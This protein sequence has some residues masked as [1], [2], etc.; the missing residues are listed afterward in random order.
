MGLDNRSPE[1]G[2]KRRAS[3]TERRVTDQK[4]C[5]HEDPAKGV[6]STRHIGEKIQTFSDS[7]QNANKIQVAT[8]QRTLV[9][10]IIGQDPSARRRSHT[11]STDE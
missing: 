4:N 10:V 6:V 3:Y 7:K 2:V 1:D 8:F 11:F 9:L 5:R